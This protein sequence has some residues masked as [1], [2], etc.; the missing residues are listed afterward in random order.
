MF[1]GLINHKLEILYSLSQNET[2]IRYVLRQI[3]LVLQFL[4]LFHLFH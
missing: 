2:I 4:N 1:V 3:D